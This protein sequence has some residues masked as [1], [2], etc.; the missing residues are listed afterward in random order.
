MKM[1]ENS[2]IA[3][4]K[5]GDRLLPILL[6]FAHLCIGPFIFGFNFY[7]RA[8]QPEEINT[9]AG[10]KT[11]TAMRSQEAWDEA[12]RVS[13]NVGLVMAICMIAYQAM[14]LFKMNAA[15]SLVT[16]M[17]FMF[18]TFIAGWGFT[19]THLN[20]RF[21]EQGRS[22]PK[23]TTTEGAKAEQPPSLAR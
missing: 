19:E 5:R 2:I 9:T 4:L 14:T 8:N 13:C 10:Y 23:E 3:M 1:H 6:L 15:A 20:R 21:D 11:A 18:L 12:Q 17:L 16:S 7:V 22:L